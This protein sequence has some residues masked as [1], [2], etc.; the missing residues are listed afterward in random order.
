M[1]LLAL[2]ATAVLCAG[3]CATGAASA[4]A[5]GSVAYGFAWSDGDG[6]LRVTPARATLVKEHGILRYKLKAVPGAKEA[7]LEYGK[8]A[9][10]RVTV[11]CD[12][13]ETEGHVALDGKGL[14]RTECK[15]S[16]LAFTLR[17]GPAPVKVEYTG[18]QAVRV[19]EFLTEWGDSKTATGTI[20]RVNDT[21]VSFKGIK[22]GY[23]HALAFNRVTAS[24]SSGWL[25][26]RP[27]NADHDGLGKKHCDAAQF[28]KTLKAQK[29]PVLVKADYNPLSGELQEVW[30]VFGDA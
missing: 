6:A 15:P 12:L 26:G 20:E 8:A 19:S 28:T 5:A 30:E 14:G 17:R 4:A 7:R 10:R 16:D 1:R 18:K 11:A 21:T 25:S 24:C 23:T 9:Y 22:L 2:T 29:H 27:V 13:V 3:L